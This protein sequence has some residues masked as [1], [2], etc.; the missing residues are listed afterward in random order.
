MFQFNNFKLF[1]VLFFDNCAKSASQS[2]AHTYIFAIVSIK[3]F[4]MLKLTRNANRLI[5]F[6]L[7]IISIITFSSCDVLQGI[8]EI[9][10]WSGIIMV[11]IVIA[12]IIFI[13]TRFKGRN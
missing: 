9:G 5:T 11:L 12:L 3:L 4:T 10:M 7:I 13:V 8:F 1:P 6:I 2:Y